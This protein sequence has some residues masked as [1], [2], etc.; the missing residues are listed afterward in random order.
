TSTTFQSLASASA[1]IFLSCVS[2]VQRSPLRS[3][4]ARTYAAT[5]FVFLSAT[6]STMQPS[7]RER[8]LQPRYVLPA[9]D[10]FRRLPGADEHDDA[11][12]QPCRHRHSLA[13]G[14][15]PRRRHRGRIRFGPRSRDLRSHSDRTVVL[16][17]S[18]RAT[19]SLTEEVDEDADAVGDG[20]QQREDELDACTEA[21]RLDRLP[22]RRPGG[23]RVL[24]ARV[25][26]EEQAGH[27]AD[28]QPEH[29]DD[30]EADDGEH[31]A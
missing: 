20:G 3:M 19:R 12:D 16:A 1:L 24:E 29:R 27:E 11:F 7:L 26:G 13:S 14:R 22:A 5:S 21:D 23:L 25:F 18:D 10:H 17:L 30:E 8:V 2:T 28:G 15:I 4:E 31:S 9:V 6:S